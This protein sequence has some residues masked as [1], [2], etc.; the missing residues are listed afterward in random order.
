MYC[1]YPPTH[2]F[3]DLCWTPNYNALVRGNGFL[4]LDMATGQDLDTFIAE[5]QSGQSASFTIDKRIE[6]PESSVVILR[7]QNDHRLV[8][9]QKKELTSP[10]QMLTLVLE[11]V[12]SRI[13]EEVDIPLA[14]VR[15]IPANL[16]FEIKPYPRY[17]ATL[18]TFAEGVPVEGVGIK[19]KVGEG[20]TYTVIKNM[21]KNPDLAKIAAIDTFL[22]NVDRHDFNLA[23][24]NGH[25]TG[26]DMGDIFQANFVDDALRNLQNMQEQG[27]RFTAGEIQGL[28]IYRD[29][30]RNL[31]TMFPL[32]TIYAYIDQ[33]IN[34]AGLKSLN[35]PEGKPLYTS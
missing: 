8:L 12:G 32:D 21:S 1:Y 20:L 4:V 19:Q 14:R 27:V 23:Y 2:Q 33:S 30:L 24:A 7:D 10:Y 6:V 17:P 29:T 26:Y 16:N 35:G 11:T 5:L 28:K 9:K 13:G 18:Q 15:I 34:Q 22:G 31:K 3:I 25:Y